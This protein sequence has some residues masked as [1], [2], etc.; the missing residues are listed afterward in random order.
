MKV[1]LSKWVS[2]MRAAGVNPSDW[3]KR[4]GLMDP[5]LP[6]TMGYEAAGFV[7]EAHAAQLHRPAQQRRP[8]GVGGVRS[9]GLGPIER[10][11]S[12][13]AAGEVIAFCAADRNY[14]GTRMLWVRAEPMRLA[15]GKAGLAMWAWVLGEKIYWTGDEPSSDRADLFAGVRLAPAPTTVW[16]FTVER[17]RGRHHG[18]GGT[19]SRILAE[20][21]DGIAKI[22]M[23]RRRRISSKAPKERLVELQIP[24]ALIDQLAEYG[25]ETSGD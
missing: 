5:E 18:S 15:L 20:R 6:Q 11:Y 8:Y 13:V 19:R 3:K 16:G 4:Q 25:A 22:P 23:A 17:E 7:A 21:A 24:A 12:W 10:E 1:S 2:R 9:L 14:G